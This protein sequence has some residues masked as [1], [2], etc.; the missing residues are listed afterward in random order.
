MRRLTPALVAALALVAGGCGGGGAA[1]GGGSVPAGAKLVS[2]ETPVF[3]SVAA[4]FEG[5]Q[6]RNGEAL[7]RKFPS[8]DKLI[9]KITAGLAEQNLDFARDVKPAFGKEVDVAL[10]DLQ[11]D[12][13]TVV[14]LTQ[15]PDEAKLEALLAKSKDTMFVTRRSG[16]WTF[17]AEKEA[18]I[19]RAMRTSGGTLADRQPFEDAMQ[20][21][22]DDSAARFFVAGSFLQDAFDKGMSDSGAP[23]GLSRRLGTLESISGAVKIERDGVAADSAL[24]TARKLGL[25][26]GRPA[27]AGELPAGALVY[28]SFSNLDA[29]VRKGLEIAADLVP[30]F[31]QQ[32]AQV[33]T[34][35]GFSIEN[36]VLPLL[37]KDGAVAVYPAPGSRIPTVI[38]ALNV[39]NESKARNLVD[40]VVSLAQ[41]GGA[42]SPR[43]VRIGGIDAEEIPVP[44]AGFSIF[45][46]VFDGKIVAS[47][48][49]RGISSLRAGGKKLSADPVYKEALSAASAPGDVVALLY[50]NLKDG[51]PLV[52]G[53]ANDPSITPEVRANLRP[54]RSAVV[55]MSQDDRRLRFSEFVTIK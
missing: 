25:R 15:P 53:L 51:I 41:L 48:T 22:P 2:G 1:T 54:L 10:Y 27:L 36:D 50:L 34:A 21:Y 7:L 9:R 45:Y 3:I 17:F 20:A 11:A 37:S 46:A 38:V 29:A 12:Q 31:S 23:M 18:D 43:K 8:H 6:W 39:P 47:N 16:G 32:R 28:L 4:D 40:R 19:D 44:N 26:Q 5:Q 14:G 24:T 42:V 33:E 55:A 52:L 35:L 13:P 49:R 30:N